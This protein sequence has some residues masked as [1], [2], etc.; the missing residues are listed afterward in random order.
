MADTP[1]DAWTPEPPAGQAEIEK[2]EQHKIASSIAILQ[3][4]FDDLDTDI[5]RLRGV[6]IIDGVNPATK[7]EHLLVAVLVSQGTRKNLMDLRQKY[8]IKYSHHIEKGADEA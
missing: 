1:Y 2:E 8:Q 5:E 4:F 3:E 7:N 6:D